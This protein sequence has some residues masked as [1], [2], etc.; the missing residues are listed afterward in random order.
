M[1]TLPD[2]VLASAADP[3]LG[4]LLLVT[5]PAWL[6]AADGRHV[7]WANAAGVS[8]F[9]QSSLGDL[10]S[11]R[12]R[13]E[14]P[15]VRQIDALARSLG[16]DGAA[17]LALLRLAAG[18]MSRPVSGLCRKLRFGDKESVL[19]VAEARHGAAADLLRRTAELLLPGAAAA[20]LGA[21]GAFRSQS[22]SWRRVVAPELAARLLPDLL[23]EVREGHRASR[24]VSGIRVELV[25]IAGE[26]G[27]CLAVARLAEEIDVSAEPQDA[28]ADSA[29]A[30][31]GPASEHAAGPAARPKTLRFT[32]RM[33]H[34]LRFTAVS[35]ELAELVGANAA[36]L[37]RS[38][39]EIAAHFGLDPEGTVA[40]ALGRR[41]AWTAANV[42]WPAVSGAVPVE[43]A[44]LPLFDA[45]QR[46]QGYRGFG[47]CRLD[48]AI[49][50]TSPGSAP[51]PRDA[52]PESTDRGG[53]VPPSE[54]P[55]HVPGKDAALDAAGNSVNIVPLRTDR[56]RAPAVA[57][58]L[59]Q[60]EHDAFREI[61][62]ALGA[63]LAAEPQLG[64][65]LD[66]ARAV[67]A[68]ETVPIGA[69]TAHRTGE[70][71]AERRPPEPAVASE[72]AVFEGQPPDRPE[73]DGREAGACEAR[74]PRPAADPIPEAR[75]DSGA[76]PA[77]FE[78]V[79][80]RLP[81][82]VLV[83]RDGFVAFANR[84]ALALFGYADTHAVNA[85][86]GMAALFANAAPIVP[87]EDEEAR[88]ARARRA[89][90][91][92]IDIEAR[93]FRLDSDGAPGVLLTVEPARRAEPI[94]ES[95]IW[96]LDMLDSVPDG[97]AVLAG[98]GHVERVNAALRD[99]LGR[100]EPELLNRPFPNLF[101][102]ESR[103]AVLE[104][105]NRAL[106]RNGTSETADA[107]IRAAKGRVPVR[108][109]IRR[110]GAEAGRLGV[111]VRDTSDLLRL[112]AEAA[113]TRRRADATVRRSAGLLERVSHGIR[114][115]L[116][117]VI[118]FAELMAE[119]RFGPLGSERYRACASD[120]RASG[121]E[122]E[123]LLEDMTRLVQIESGSVR[124]ALRPASL[125]QVV[126]QSVRQLQGEAQRGRTLVRTSLSAALPA[127]R[128]DEPSLSRA[129]A[130]LL[131]EV[132]AQARNGGQVIVSTAA[133]ENGRAVLRI[134]GA[135][136][137]GERIRTG[138]ATA[139]PAEIRAEP[140][141]DRGIGSALADAVIEAHRG[142]I[143]R[144]GH[145]GFGLLVEV[146][147]PPA[148]P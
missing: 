102:G 55:A 87:S 136:A 84:R 33:D 58:R 94:A 132:L 86:G 74:D 122:L 29:G 90:G 147:L 103:F 4:P 8:F 117:A 42:S 110:I 76:Y 121:R 39:T 145:A 21:D 37:G 108:L 128:A 106:R 69:P 143:H 27:L 107:E 7:L 65:P 67:A 17:R 140:I 56:S 5:S 6:F 54:P 79:L 15:S 47:I 12:F 51:P 127:I 89:D 44:G 95:G 93:L 91:E 137:A 40:R 66:E 125:N 134:R 144:D 81:L 50:A 20:F 71:P 23:R 22:E 18:S 43:L 72:P 124:L 78:S 105:L 109:W 112:D 59:A 115:P 135:S 120:I 129:V 16:A 139:Q 133:G 2:D 64:S 61:A 88:P 97:L 70:H 113:E 73:P 35:P 32:W 77:G 80:D 52:R 57:Q 3:R 53:P 85:A 101:T 63:K 118:G 13:P 49:P 148:E 142:T 41:E 83:L 114:G 60:H 96:V 62:R 99:L 123:A 30:A 46:F 68:D 10:K 130:H 119:E 45:D 28:G 111:V 92:P 141:P 131:A 146:S 11:R 82:G 26:E 98:N 75:Q 38:W 104:G 34:A 116:T 14:A 19:V 24:S 48:R 100:P 9:G 138:Q 126:E 25:R 1:C 31:P 36:V